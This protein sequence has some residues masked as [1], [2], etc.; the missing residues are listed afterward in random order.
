MLNAAR[1]GDASAI[2]VNDNSFPGVSVK[3]D[4]AGPPY[5]VPPPGQPNP[6]CGPEVI[7]VKPSTTYRFRAIGATAIILV[8]FAFED[9]DILTVIAADGQYAKPVNVDRIQINSGQRF[10]FLLKTKSLEEIEELGKTDFWIQVEN[11]YRPVNL[12]S[13]AVLSYCMSDDCDN[14]V[15]YSRPKSKVLS[16]TNDIQDWLEYTLEQLEPNG[17]PHTSEVNRMVFIYNRQF[18]PPAGMFWTANNRTWTELDEHLHGLPFLTRASNV[19]AP[20]LVD[21][22]KR[23]EAAV[24]NYQ[25]AIDK[26]GGWSPDYNA[27]VARVGEV[28]DIVF[29]NEPN[30][31]TGG[32]DIH[33][34]HIH[35]GHVYDL[36]S[37]PGQYNREAHLQRLDG[38]NPVLRDTTSVYKYVYGD[39]INVLPPYSPQGWRAW[40]LR[41]EDAG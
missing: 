14:S 41:V 26:Y 27:Y 34:W 10:D 19:G 37:G 25:S 32:F 16:I 6:P 18:D 4:L 22:Y 15:V 23:G 28:I 2:L 35:G 13:Y 30:N 11:K 9:H 1:S 38:Y 8:A 3:Q 36:G 39:G 33:P 17:F 24:P 5:Y 21:I 40:R 31:L 29:I 12:T 7:A 20:Y